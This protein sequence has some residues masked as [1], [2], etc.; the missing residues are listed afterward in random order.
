AFHRHHGTANSLPDHKLRV[1]YERNALFTIYKCFEGQ[2]LS[3]VLPTALLLI[4]E[5]ALRLANHDPGGFR[6][7]GDGPPASVLDRPERQL[8]TDRATRVL[9]D[10]CIAGA[11]IKVVKLVRW[12]AKSGT[13][14]TSLAIARRLR[15]D[16]VPQPRHN[17]VWWPSIAA[18]HFEAVSEF[19]HVLD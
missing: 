13:A 15:P 16:L 8:L 12:V 14:K 7:Q 6:V 2:N 11:L 5:R 3:L 17:H 1:L 18:S 10:E 19:A 4:N 9:R